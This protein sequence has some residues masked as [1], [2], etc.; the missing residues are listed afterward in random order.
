[1]CQP[2]KDSC[3]ARLG[4]AGDFVI[5]GQRTSNSR[6]CKRPF[7]VAQSLSF[8]ARLSVQLL[9]WEWVFILMQIKLIFARKG[10]PPFWNWKVLDLGNGLLVGCRG[11]ICVSLYLEADWW[12]PWKGKSSALPL[13]PPPP[14]WVAKPIAVL[15]KELKMAVIDN[16]ALKQYLHE[17]QCNTCIRGTLS[18]VSL[19]QRNFNITPR[20]CSL[21]CPLAFARKFYLQPSGHSFLITSLLPS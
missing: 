5:Y 15:S 9:E 16:S 13:P 6:Y 8:K 7:R 1:M 21:L 12:A 3:S 17:A 20:V 11:C 4:D 10:V 14:H 19:A 2:R 18:S